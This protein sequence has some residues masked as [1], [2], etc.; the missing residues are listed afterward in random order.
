M[1]FSFRKSLN[2]GGL[3]LNFSKSGVGVSFGIKGLRTGINAKGKKYI[4]ASSN[5]LNYKKFFIF[6]F[7]FVIFNVLNVQANE[8]N[9][10]HKLDQNE[11]KQLDNYY[12]LNLPNKILWT[13]KTNI[14]SILGA[15]FGDEKLKMDSFK[16]YSKVKVVAVSTQNPVCTKGPAAMFCQYKTT[17][18]D[19]YGNKNVMP[20]LV[21]YDYNKKIYSIFYSDIPFAD[22]DL[23]YFLTKNPF[24][25]LEKYS[26]YIKLVQNGEIMLGMPEKMLIMSWGKPISINENVGSWGVHKQYVYGD[27]GP[28]V[29]VE[30][31]KVTSWQN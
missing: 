23:S 20:I 2:L 31:G 24:A 19:D 4:S 17:F 28:Y 8:V 25:G 18:M 6:T 29:Y 13:H 21:F 7:I 12:K 14:V 26:K 3:K 10:V 5:G 16:N 15:S 30:N 27:F 9:I 22:E 11:Q 1:G